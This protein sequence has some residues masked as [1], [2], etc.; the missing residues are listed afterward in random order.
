MDFIQ[1]LC[2]M[3]VSMPQSWS[4]SFLTG[5]TLSLI[6]RLLLILCLKFCYKRLSHLGNPPEHHSDPETH[7]MGQVPPQVCAVWPALQRFRCADNPQP[8]GL[9]KHTNSFKTQ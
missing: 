3:D 4:V 7:F 2:L 8:S 9:F 1:L 6:D 5:L